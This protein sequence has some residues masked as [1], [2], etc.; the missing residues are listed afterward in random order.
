[1]SE[2]NGPKFNPNFGRLV[3]TRKPNEGVVLIVGGEI[4]ARVHYKTDRNKTHLVFESSPSVEILREELIAA[5]LANGK[6][7]TRRSGRPRP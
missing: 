3:L 1:M 5:W 2:N 6:Q 4:V 7:L